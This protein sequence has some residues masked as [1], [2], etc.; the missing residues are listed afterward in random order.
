MIKNIEDRLCTVSWFLI[1]EKYF[2][3]EVNTLFF[4][5]IG[6]IQIGVWT[7]K[8]INLQFL[9]SNKKVSITIFIFCR[10]DHFTTSVTRMYM[11]INE[12]IRKK[13]FKG[14]N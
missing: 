1:C 12:D 14:S 8:I 10:F 9:T 2:K 4:D 5:I 13:E 6:H 11:R 3:C 7:K